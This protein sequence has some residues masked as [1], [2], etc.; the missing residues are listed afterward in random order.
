MSTP[1]IIG[2]A[3][4]PTEDAKLSSSDVLNSMTGHDEIA[5][6][7]AFGKTIETLSDT[8]GIGFLRALVFVVEVHGGAKHDAAK[9]TVLD[10]TIG[11][12]NERFESD[13]VD[14]LP[15]SEAGKGDG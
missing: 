2:P 7:K 10:M 1:Q 9:A 11:E 12:L 8:T 15:G 14:E 13:P 3:P 6:E 5:V 4:A